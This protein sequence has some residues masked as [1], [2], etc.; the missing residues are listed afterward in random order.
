M[1]R[2][3]SM[4]LLVLK[5]A[6]HRNIAPNSQSSSSPKPSSPSS[7][8]GSSSEWKAEKWRFTSIKLL[9]PI[10]SHPLPG[11]DCGAGTQ[12][13]CPVYMCECMLLTTTM[14][15]GKPP[16][17]RDEVDNAAVP[18]AN[19]CES[20]VG[21]RDVVP[22]DLDDD[23]SSA[24]E[25]EVGVNNVAGSVVGGVGSTN[26]GV[27]VVVI[28]VE[29]GDTGGDLDLQQ[30]QPLPS[31]A[32]MSEEVVAR[33]KDGTVLNAEACGSDKNGAVGSLENRHSWHLDKSLDK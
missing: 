21:M 20:I 9:S 15:T 27:A 26:E 1:H 14:E 7:P 30:E 13:K 6:R 16:N 10:V 5:A 17:A 25:K 24:A 4:C 28:S 2:I 29:N 22:S 12:V 8:S 32:G 18:V 3:C 19:G 23:Y 31:P 11:P 33:D